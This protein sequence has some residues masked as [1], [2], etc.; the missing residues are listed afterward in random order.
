MNRKILFL[1]SIVIILMNLTIIATL[2]KSNVLFSSVRFPRIHLL[3][4]FEEI[5]DSLQ[6]PAIGLSN[7]VKIAEGE[8]QGVAFMAN[9]VKNDSGSRGY[10]YHVKLIK[11][12]EA[13]ESILLRI[14]ID[15]HSGEIIGH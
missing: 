2:T 5:I 10:I 4:N 8:T 12:A 11:N 3:A 13:E 9:L 14:D 15:A 1:L 6:N 7:A